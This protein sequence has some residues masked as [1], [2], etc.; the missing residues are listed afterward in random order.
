MQRPASVKGVFLFVVIVLGGIG[1]GAGIIFALINAKYDRYTAAALSELESIRAM[2]DVR[3]NLLLYNRSVILFEST[4]D[5]RHRE[6]AALAK[7]TVFASVERAEVHA[8]DVPDQQRLHALA[9]KLS[10]Y[11][12]LRDRL[13]D[14]GLSVEEQTEISAPL[15]DQILE[16]SGTHL[17]VAQG[18][19]RRLQKI[20]MGMGTGITISSF[21]LS[22]LFT[23]AIVSLLMI[24]SREVFA[25]FQALLRCIDDYKGGNLDARAPVNGPRELRQIGASFN[26][27]TDHLA[28]QHR[29]RYEFLLAVTHDLRNPLA[30]LKGTVDLAARKERQGSLDA[31]QR[32]EK[33]R[34]I[35]DLVGRLNRMI[36]DLMEMSRVEANRLE[37]VLATE[38]LRSIAKEAVQLFEESSPLHP[39]VLELPPQPLPVVCDST[40]LLQVLSN[41]LSNA[42]KYSPGGGE[43]VV[44]GGCRGADA[45]IEVQD[46]GMGIPEEKQAGIFEPFTRLHPQDGPPGV[47]LGLSVAL[48]LMKEHGGTIEVESEEGVGSRFRMLLPLVI[49]KPPPARG[50]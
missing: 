10:R 36:S 49:D 26:E 39:L 8:L 47:G 18:E 48:R 7:R 3:E 19:A 17:I 13:A 16:I 30:A 11:F 24:A 1:L 25:P 33:Y 21:V 40:R 50:G 29:Q 2:A 4:G 46:H 5:V 28:A 12:K 34:R 9:E 32:Q 31:E 14:S 22:A 41:L 45:F 35:A 37:L 43:I 38:D 23:V 15:F 44:R 6:D 27:L 20:L 42:I